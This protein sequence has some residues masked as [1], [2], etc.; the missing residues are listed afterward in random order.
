MFLICF[1]CKHDKGTSNE[2]VSTKQYEITF[3]KTYDNGLLTATID[4]KV[5]EG[6][7]VEKGKTI[8]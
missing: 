5:F 2:G 7:K 6:G 3:S 8:I 4:G 1:A